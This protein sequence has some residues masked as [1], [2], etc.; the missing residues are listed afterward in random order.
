MFRLIRTAT[1]KTAADINA[2]LQF[3]AEMTSYLNRTYSLNVKFGVEQFSDSRI[4]WH[5]ESDSLDKITQL[6]TKLLQDRE[7]CGMVNKA[8]DLWVVGGL[9]DTVI[10]FL[11]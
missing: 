6:H 8:R 9:K 11:E 5:F 2:A 7:Y 10:A 1:P 3:A 4:H